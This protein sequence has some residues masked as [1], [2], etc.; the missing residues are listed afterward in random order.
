MSSH[1]TFIAWMLCLAPGAWA[2]TAIPIG[3]ALP[4]SGSE[5]KSGARVKDGYDLAVKM[6]NEKG[7]LE[8][9]TRRV[10]VVLKIVDDKSDPAVDAEMIRQLVAGGSRLL[11]GTFSTPL[12]E[13]GSAAAEKADVPYVSPTG[14]S[15]AL[16]RRGFKNL[17]SVQAPIDMLGD[18]LMRWIDDQQQQGKLPTPARVALVWEN[19]AHGKEFAA[20]VREFTTRTPR[21]RGAYRLVI[22]E[23]FELNAK[24]FKGLLGRVRDAKADLLLVDSH[25]PD[26]ITMQTEYAKMGLCHKALSYGARGPE[27][28]AREK[29]KGAS[30]YILSAVWWSPRMNRNDRNGEFIGRFRA[31]YK[32]DPEWYEALGYEAARALFTAV[33]KAGSVD[34]AAVRKQLDRLQ[35]ESI[36]PGGNLRFEE[37]YGRQAQYPFVVQQNMP[38]GSAPVIYPRIAAEK[39]GVSPNPMCAGTRVR[40]AAR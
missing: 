21:R 11:L 20:G 31:E 29:L 23:G 33:Q 1:R 10:P 26:Y 39:D 14:A 38:D 16:Y 22:D 5:A 4:L 19:T 35:M 25:L 40:A 24:D 32:R 36:L 27:R 2:A 28:D 8:M 17:Y 3:A 34:S 12:V 18:T 6:V 7:G 15:E 13:A 37:K 9:G 30:D